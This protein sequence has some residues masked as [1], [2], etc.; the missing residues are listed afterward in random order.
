MNEKNIKFEQK[1]EILDNIKVNY[2]IISKDLY[3]KIY[4]FIHYKKYHKEVNQNIIIDLL[5]Y[6]IKN[7]LLI[8]MYYP[9]ISNFKFFRYF[10]NSEFIIEIVSVLKPLVSMK[11]DILINE[12]DYIEDIIL[13][14][15]GILSL[16]IYIDLDNPYEFL[17]KYLIKYNLK[18]I[19]NKKSLDSNNELN[20]YRKNSLNS[21]NYSKNSINFNK[22]NNNSIKSI[23]SKNFLINIKEEKLTKN[24]FQFIKIINIRKKEHFGDELMFLNEP[25]PLNLRVKSK[26]AEVL[27]LSKTDVVKISCNFPNIWKRMNERSIFNLEQIKILIM[28][29]LSIFC[30]S[31]G[32]KIKSL[33]Y[34][35]DTKTGQKK[36]NYSLIPIP[37]PIQ[38]DILNQNYYLNET[39]K[40]S[41]NNS[42]KYSENL[43]EKNTFKIKEAQSSEESITNS[44]LTKEIKFSHVN[45]KKTLKRKSNSVKISNQKEYGSDKYIK[46]KKNNK[47]Y[48]RNLTENQDRSVTYSISNS[49]ICQKKNYVLSSKC[50]KNSIKTNISKTNTGIDN[51]IT[52]AKNSSKNSRNSYLSNS[53]IPNSIFNNSL[54]SFPK[55]IPK[56]QNFAEKSKINKKLLSIPPFNFMQNNNINNLNYQLENVNDEIYP[57][58]N[59]EIKIPENDQNLIINNNIELHENSISNCSLKKLLI[60]DKKNPVINIINKSKKHI[61][62][63]NNLN[64][65]KKFNNLQISSIS[66]FE[67][68][69]SYDN[70]NEFTKYRFISNDSLI[71]KTKIFLSKECGLLYDINTKFISMPYYTPTHNRRK[72]SKSSIK[73]SKYLQNK[74]SFEHTNSIN[75]LSIINDNDIKSPTR[76]SKEIA[77]LGFKKINKNNDS[78]FENSFKDIRGLYKS[79]VHIK[80]NSTIKDK[81]GMLKKGNSTCINMLSNYSSKKR[82]RKQGISLDN[83]INIKT[84][85]K[86]DLISKNME[87][88]NQNLNNPNEFYADLFNNYYQ[89]IIKKESKQSSPK[90]K[91]KQITKEK[92]NSEKSEI[93]EKK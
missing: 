87:R 57:N 33:Y 43:N 71:K 61:D 53:P 2:P 83:L 80:R 91:I 13:N 86:L 4:R 68:K 85:N 76:F 54:T 44:I 84:I 23:N 28:R 89:Q 37:N 29:K 5:P 69:S 20:S 1:I 30:D 78:F 77:K 9:I 31:N 34:K 82:K 18:N 42:S 79:Y 16:E 72:T 92:I 46:S 27:L 88:D 24:E 75:N 70:I 41:E 15:S 64:P 14:K 21:S 56:Q 49:N 47:F 74:K 7:N 63:S 52:N 17:K 35:K 65:N 93:G 48:D 6:S 62:D 55:R 12:G 8:Q 11:G 58:E 32:I 3:R 67:I 51:K 39:S 19:K 22:I 73:I 66:A 26:I 90:N 36:I 45:S 38:E 40:D 59:F 50:K 10:G 81:I 60:I 25:S